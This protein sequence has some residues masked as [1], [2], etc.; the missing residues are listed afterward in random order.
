MGAWDL[1]AGNFDLLFLEIFSLGQESYGKDV[2]FLLGF[3]MS[4]NLSIFVFIFLFAVKILTI[5]A[6]FTLC[7]FLFSKP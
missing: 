4:V 3:L 2:F 7:T 5:R 1:K 6:R